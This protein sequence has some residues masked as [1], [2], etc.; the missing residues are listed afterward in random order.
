MR[1]YGREFAAIVGLVAIALVVSWVIVQNQRLR[2]PV[3]EERPFELKAEFETA[4]AVVPGQGQT[5][6]VAG[7]RIGDV[8]EVELEDGVA[9]VTFAI[10]RDYVPIYRDATIL[11]RPQTALKDMFF[12]LDPGSEG[13]GEIEEGETIELANT[14]PDVNLDEVLTELDDDS[15]AY[16]RLL[17]MGLGGGLEGRGEELGRTLG[18]IG[19]VNRDLERLN[20]TL[21]ARDRE[22]AR[23][24]TNLNLLTGEV[25]DHDD[26]IAE[27]VDASNEAIGAIAEQS[28]DVQRLVSLLP[29]TLATAQEAL[30]QTAPFATALGP[31]LR[32][33]RPL[34][35]RLDE[36]AT[37]T[38][39]LADTA[40]PVLQNRI[41]P[42][43]R[44]ARPV[45][46]HLRRAAKRFA[47]AT[48]PL[49]VVSEKINRLGNM[50]AY[51]PRGAED[52]GT[53]G[54]DEGYLYWLAWFTNNGTSV[55]SG[56]D[57]HG[58]YRRLYLTG[59]CE[60]LRGLIDV[61]PLG[62]AFGALQMG[63]GPL[64]GP[65]GECAPNP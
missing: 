43:V 52:P 11:M 10:D 42:L 49:T 47:A 9:V 41:R 27:L 31:T 8:Q 20:T 5:I 33:L 34:A 65:G 57:A 30:A 39:S 54:R 60:Q 13:A 53:A 61:S 63:L 1:T 14:A 36:V 37:A 38:H 59:S 28:P 21:A 12:A 18:S 16:L 46:P 7:V 15:R 51:N 58:T 6:R 19:P 22:L 50:A 17:V 48:P 4:Q 62:P 44:A 29:G 55:F 32:D 23:L 35:G 24:I 3:L 56:Q 45:V 26:D 25:G 40:T 2:V 64:F